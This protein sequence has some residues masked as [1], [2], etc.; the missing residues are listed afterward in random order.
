MYVTWKGKRQS[1]TEVSPVIA[2]GADNWVLLAFSHLVCAG[3][4]DSCRDHTIS[5]QYL[6]VLQEQF[7]D[8]NWYVSGTHGL[9]N[10]TNFQSRTVYSSWVPEKNQF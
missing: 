6:Y 2:H 1:T 4:S 8:K 5:I 7:H 9:H 10:E 3:N